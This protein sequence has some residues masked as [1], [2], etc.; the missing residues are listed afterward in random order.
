M[1]DR[2]EKETKLERA[3]A[4]HVHT[5]QNN[6]NGNNITRIITP[7][8]VLLSLFLVVVFSRLLLALQLVLFAF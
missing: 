4:A 2:N 5:R 8:L 7:T 3:T 6:Y 1:K